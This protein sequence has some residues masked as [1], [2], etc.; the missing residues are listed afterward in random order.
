MNQSLQNILK[1]AEESVNLSEEQK[2]QFAAWVKEVDK[3]LAIIE[4]KLDRTEKVKKTTAILLEET[5]EELEQKRKA[6]EAQNKE[7]E[8]EAALERVRSRSMGMHKSDELKEVIRLVLEQFVHLKINAEHAGFYID[9]K[10]HDDMHIWLADP[11]I[12]PF[13]A[14]IPYFD[15]PTWN[16]FLE[17]KAKGTAFHTDLLDF[18]EKNRFYNSLF[19][20][21]TVPEEA[22]EF[23]LR[24]KGLAVSTV[25]L[26]T[27]G[28]YI[29]NFSGIPYSDEE[30]KIL[31]RFGKVFQQTYTRFL[32]LQKA[33]AQVRE[34]QIQLGLE[35]ARAQSMMMQHSTELD[36]TLRVFHEQV[37]HLGIPSAFSF[38]WLPDEDKD[39]HIFWAAWAES[40]ST[41]FKSK[42]INYPLDRNEPATAQCLVDWKSNEPVAAYRVSP[43]GVAAYF[44]AWSELIAGVEQLKPEYFS[45]GLYYVEAFM[46][47]GCFGV[48]VRNELPE[49]E[50]KILARF[51][52]EF[53]QTYTRFLD[54]QKAERQTRESQVQLALERVRART[55]A[56]QQS[57]E[58]PDAAN[59]LFQQIQ[60][61]GMPA[62]SAGYCIW[63][64]DK[65]AVTLWMSSEGVLQPPFQAP[66]TEDELFIEMRKGQEDGKIFHV[67]EMGG[68]KL[69]KHYQYMRTLPLM[70][71]ILD[72]IIA[73]GHPLPTFQIMHHAYFSKGFLLFITYEPVPDAHDIFKRFGKVFEQT[74]TRFL[75]LQN[76][77]AQSRESQIQ[78]ALERVRARTMAMQKSDE[79]GEAASLLFQQIR[80]L[81]IESYVSGFTIWEN[82]DKDL[83]SWMCNADGSVNP[84]FRMPAQEID[85]HRQQY[86]SWK[87]KDEY[88][89]H[90]FTGN[91]MRDYYSYLRSF[92]LLNEAF[93][94]SEAAGVATPVRQVHNAFNFAHGNLLFITLQQV[95]DAYDIF[96]RFAI[97]FDQTYTRFL[98]LK[99]AEAQARESQ[100]QLALERVRART[101]A[102]QKS[103]ELSETAVLLFHQLMSL[104]L[105]VKGCGFNIWEK[106][107]TTCTSWMS[108]PDGELSPP[109]RL[110]L[111][112][113]PLFIRYYESRQK[114]EDFFVYE[115]GKEELVNRYKHLQTLPVLGKAITRE[116][117]EGKEIPSFVVDHVVNFSK[118]NLIFIT[119]EPCPDEWEIFKR[120][121]KVFEQT[122]TRFLDLQKAEEQTR[123]AQIEA[124]LE[125]VRA[126]SMAM[127]QSNDLHEVIKVVADQY[128]ALNLKFDSV[129][130]NK[131]DENRN[132]DLF[133][134]TTEHPYP[135]KISVPYI[136]N[137]IFKSLTESKDA[138]LEFY[139]GLF[140]KEDKDDFFNHFFTNTSAKNIPKERQQYVLDG[141][142]Y[143]VSAFTT[144]YITLTIA[145]YQGNP[146]ND[147]TNGIFKRFAK[148]FEQTYTRFLDLQ[149]AETQAR[150]SQIELGLE[151]VRNRAMAMQSSEEVNALIGTVFTELTKLDLVLTR[152][153]IWVFEPATS[154]TKW[155]MA[156]IEE[157]S[158]PMSF[159]IKYHEHPAYLT[160]VREWKNQNVKFVYDLKGQDKINWDD[161]LFNET[162]LKNLPEIV[163][164]GMK[165]SGRILLSASFNNFGGI[166]VASLEPLS[167]EHFDILLRFAR[168]FDLTY[169][170]FLDLQKAEAQ[171]REARIETALERVRSRTMAMHQTSELQEVIHAV[172]K[173]LLN[174]S[175]SIDGGSFVVINNDIGTEL[176]CWGA[177][178]T[179][180]TSEEVLV[181]HFDM[182]FC[183]NLVKGIKR[184][185]GFFTE[186][187]SRDEKQ[188][189]FT[190]LFEHSPWSDIS[191]EEKSKTISS[192]GGYTRSVAVSNHTSIFIVNHN[193]KKFT[194]DENDI[195]K[196]FSKVFEQTYTRFLDLQKAETQ[197]RESQIQLALE[198]V[199]ARTMAMQHSD[200]L[201]DASLVLDTQVRS[202]G[203]KTRGCAFNIYGDGESLEWFSSE[204]GSLPMYKTP[205]E[206]LFLRYFEKGRSGTPLYIE[207]FTGNDCAAHYE[208]LC[209][210]P[211]MG[212]ELKA[213]IA[214]GGSFPTRQIDHVTY[215]KYG[216]LL[217]I[218]LEPEPEAHEIFIRF[219]KVFEQTYTRFL[220]LQKSEAQAREAKIEAAMEKVRA[221]AM[222][223]QKP[224]GLVEVAELLR[225]EMSLLGVE[226]LETSSIYIHHEESG[227][228]ECWFAIR[229]VRDGDKKLIADYMNMQLKDTCVGKEML[230]FYSSNEKQISI[231]MQGE[232]RKEW[233]NY[234]AAH[235]SL[236]QGYYGDVIPERTYHLIKFSNG[237]MGAASPGDISTESWDLLKRATNVFSLAYTRFSDL[238]LAE[239]QARE[240]QVETALERVRSRTLAMQKSDELSDTA[241]E[242]FRQLIG[243][244]M[245]PNRLYIGIV[246]GDTRDMEM[247]ATDE[248]GTGVGK[249]FTFN[250]ADN[251]SVKKL[252]DGWAEKIKSVTVDMHG[253]E[254]QNYIGYLQHLQIPLSHAL[255]QKRRVQSVAYFDKGFIGMASPDEQSESSIHLLERF[256]AVF[257]LT[258][259]RF[260]DLKIAEAHA[261]QAEQ[262]LIEIKAARKKAEDTLTE[263]Q[264]TQRQLVQSEKMAS[265]GELTAGIAHEIQN[266]LNFVNNFSEINNELIEEMKQELNKGDIE[267]AK[268]IIE[269]IK[270]NLEKINHHGKR[271]DSIVKGMLQH[272]QRSAGEKMPTD[273][274]ALADEYLRLAYHGIRAKDK[275]FNAKLETDFDTQIGKVNIIPQDIGRVVLNILTNAFYAVNEKKKSA[276]ENYHPTVLVRTKKI[277]DTVEIVINDNGNGIPK[278]IVDKIFQ[279]FFTTKPTGQGTGLGLSLA[280]DIV[281]AHG[282][283][284]KVET[285]ED[286]GT[287]FIIQLSIN[288]A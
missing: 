130:I 27:V 18:E 215:H 142:G 285:K 259:T 200:E 187:F 203:I 170:R 227:L 225:T 143:A 91:E 134:S 119:Y 132:W 249:K 237:F 4:F 64:E 272:S 99:K 13:F 26:D 101:M 17:A 59:I 266:P 239:A 253:V 145:N 85:W 280:Y 2:K 34:S 117:E 180:N 80:S 86:K 165:A 224:A 230:R 121:G 161:I 210:I 271:A 217:F 97:V 5:I 233:I 214:A 151:R 287:T 24:C 33:E 62:W 37:L 220:D 141:K 140:S 159:Y 60:S 160:F 124:A 29:E 30:N 77:E 153:I 228:T 50:K 196:R 190:K 205:R 186:E 267:E 109:F 41:V 193:G 61:L 183:T 137:K 164:E 281:K 23:Y 3:Q 98:D 279:P 11:N 189:Y 258:F 286:E 73:A 216:Y 75:D 241:A 248:D 273:I 209:T 71:D 133:I 257:N 35:R 118:G 163:K 154:A 179:A 221:K 19:K 43:E 184:G 126:S 256:A 243:L 250:A 39:R 53:E 111:A 255:T 148:V 264:A 155:W 67:A 96:K 152:C 104:E 94:K 278:N 14:I 169:T 16:S 92:P 244:G 22:K 157:P 247:W 175:L 72:S 201:A 172:H 9:Y 197:A 84:P 219:A 222:A 167:D 83:I 182:P 150:Q 28:L 223:M 147:E 103:D 265:L 44:A 144:K 194:E 178:G 185:V 100:I 42:A 131:V 51:A 206:N 262:D 76:A 56:M 63:N 162:E 254:L 246:N 174:L 110:P 89:I 166:N 7:L 181:P 40:N 122:Y 36:D 234:C 235:S 240:A 129:S 207:E 158:N 195:L 276:D 202:L 261:L 177:G 65:S 211:I 69:V 146:F 199:R 171:A 251:A 113:D 8:I 70:G 213:M 139:T 82:D 105:N 95:P 123:E 21:F 6:V 57:N 102:M 54:L 149:K 1:L 66:T 47:Y 10:G 288:N 282:G 116:L 263:L 127:H 252:Y 136:N 52:V 275:S 45:G 277:N 48:M 191:S 25:L 188:E 55:M 125:R 93:E 236:L 231:L 269:D 78:L 38:L 242:V 88:V 87:N 208:Y 238:Q 268:F 232:N 260:N 283:E 168:V 68:E 192:P 106:G 20:L 245:E 138:G 198:R 112:G 31:M 229:D 107:E 32:D 81:G 156:N 135:A 46:K 15:T 173:E 74:Y 212:D 226:E 274:N 49:D 90:D 128:M 79:L 12:E 114:G 58:L 176:R 120:F 108:G 284:L 115:T 204:Q 218:T 270:Q